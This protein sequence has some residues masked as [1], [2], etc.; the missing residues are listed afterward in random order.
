MTLHGEFRKTDKM[1]LH[2][3]KFGQSTGVNAPIP[4]KSTTEWSHAD[5]IS[6]KTAP[7]F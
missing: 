6:S 4:V 5:H 2:G 1:S 3:L 7:I